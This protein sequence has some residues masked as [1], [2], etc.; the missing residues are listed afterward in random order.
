MVSCFGHVQQLPAERM[1]VANKKTLATT[2]TVVLNNTWEFVISYT[3]YVQRTRQNHMTV[4][5]AKN[6]GA[7]G[8]KEHLTKQTTCIIIIVTF[9]FFFL[10]YIYIILSNATRSIYTIHME[11]D[12]DRE[13]RLSRRWSASSFSHDDDTAVCSGVG[14][15]EYI[16]V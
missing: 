12:L 9:C 4:N 13:G 6:T 2:K 5:T 1:K 8:T 11:R 16:R 7:S 14:G 3:M 15:G 10:F